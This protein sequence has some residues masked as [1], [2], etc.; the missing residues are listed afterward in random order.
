MTG[1]GLSPA[2]PGLAGHGLAGIVLAA[3]A[4]SRFGQPK[5]LVPF[6][7]ELLVE[8]AVRLLAAGGCQPVWAVLGASAGEVHARADLAGAVPVLAEDWAQG[9]GASLRAGLAAATASA[10][11]AVIVA[12]ADQPLIGVP[13]LQRL[14]A[15]WQ[16][17]AV[18]AVA[19]Y[20]GRPRNPVLLTRAIWAEVAQAAVGDVGARGWLRAHPE[21]VTVVPCDGTGD[22][23][24]VDTPDDLDALLEE[25][26]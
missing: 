18:A 2:A 1:S 10:A 21:L 13:A 8:R 15:A 19:G 23:V 12:L 17:G 20:A 11:Q 25:T 14:R 6:R 24:D 5:A 22:P 26:R 3:G 4:G 9:M 7:G 16:A